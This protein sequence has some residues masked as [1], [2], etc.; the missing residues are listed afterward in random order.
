MVERHRWGRWT[1]RTS[2]VHTDNI[3][4]VIAFIRREYPA[5]DRMYGT[6]GIDIAD[7]AYAAHIQQHKNSFIS[8]KTL[9]H[10][11]ETSANK[12]AQFLAFFFG[13]SPG[14]AVALNEVHI[15]GKS[16]KKRT[17]TAAMVVHVLGLLKETRQVRW[18][19]SISIREECYE[20]V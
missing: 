19:H 8:D 16:C 15:K 4:D 17:I 7:L 3:N 2:K 6:T 12:R 9:K 14:Q 10:K 18:Y 1:M 20:N 11:P 13:I 5:T